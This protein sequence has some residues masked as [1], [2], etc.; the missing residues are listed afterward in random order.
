[1]ATYF[2]AG[3]PKVKNRL[4]RYSFLTIWTLGIPVLS[5]YGARIVM[6]AAPADQ[7]EHIMNNDL[8]G[9]KT[10]GANLLADPSAPEQM[11]TTARGIMNQTWMG[12]TGNCWEYQMP[13]SLTHIKQL[14]ISTIINNPTLYIRVRTTCFSSL[15]KLPQG[16]PPIAYSRTAFVS[17]PFI[18]EFFVDSPIRDKALSFFDSLYFKFA[19]GAAVLKANLILLFS[20]FILFYF[21]RDRV[22]GAAAIISFSATIFFAGYFFIITIGDFRF[23]TWVLSSVVLSTI[24]TVV[25]LTRQ[26]PNAVVRLLRK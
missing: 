9:M 13:R 25:F 24:L 20:S 15:L 7:E 1:M 14:W 26:I 23:I 19:Y 6:P 16:R 5:V 17:S 3:L 4:I 21:T 8:I 18:K 12:E 10:L 2:L 11:A 22:I